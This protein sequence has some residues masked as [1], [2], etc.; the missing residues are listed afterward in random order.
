M[1]IKKEVVTTYITSDGAKHSEL[2]MAEI[3]EKSIKREIDYRV[4][5]VKVMKSLGIKHNLNPTNPDY[6]TGSENWGDDMESQENNGLYGL[7]ARLEEIS[8][9]PGDMADASDLIDTIEGWV[10]VLGG[11]TKIK[12]LLALKRPWSK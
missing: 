5:D 7:F 4:F 10:D 1:A 11:L 9:C 6:I 3:R 12:N 2:N 8:M